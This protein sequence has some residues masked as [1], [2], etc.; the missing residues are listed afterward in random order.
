MRRDKPRR[1]RIVWALATAL[2]IAT[3]AIGSRN[4]SA[5]GRSGAAQ[6]FIA[7]KPPA[8]TQKQKSVR[9]RGENPCNTPDP[10]F[11]GFE[12]WSREVSMGQMIAPKRKRAVYDVM[13]HFHGHEGARKEWV[14]VM[15][16]GVL[17]GIDLG[18]GSGPY[19]TAFRGGAAFSTLLQSV[20]RAAKKRNPRAR[21][22]R[23]GVSA[24]SAGY[25]AIQNIL[26]SPEHRSR[27][28]SV[29]LLDGLHCSYAGRSLNEGQ[30]GPFIAFARL[31]AAGK[32]LMVVTHSSIVP[33]GYAS[34]TE[35]ANYLVHKLG[36]K[37]Q[38]TRPRASD[39][40]GLE[41]ISRYS[42]G[43]FHMRGFAGNDKL[44]HCA[45]LGLYRD[46]LKAHIRPRWS[47]RGRR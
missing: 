31:A 22:G 36:G 47:A 3:L 18:L 14:R 21:L 20:E 15:D 13:I 6:P 10:G 26:A 37:P 40:L 1:S 34:T 23:I 4:A 17:V 33:P 25:G 12:R 8:W 9:E 27:I 11:G 39:P 7:P 16:G 24:W 19:E 46:V 35:T 32:K 45:H 28:D 29:V 2:G 44:D 30:L 43:N 38:A 42:R 41:L 5:I